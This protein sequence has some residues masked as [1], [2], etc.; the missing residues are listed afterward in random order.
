MTDLMVRKGEQA[1]ATN[2]H[3]SGM[4]FTPRFDIWEDEMEYVLSGDLPGVDPQDVEIC[5]EKQELTIRGK[6]A[7][8]DDGRQYFME[9]YGIGDFYRTFTVGEMIDESVIN[10]ELKDGMLVV[11]LPKKAESR[12]R[13]I[14]VK[15]G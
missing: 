4:W 15:S 10:A 6:V 14:A 9:E 7:S 12:P 13:K 2:G 8:R 3:P 1:A 5:Y 11:H